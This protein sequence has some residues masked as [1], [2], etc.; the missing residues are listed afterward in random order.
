VALGVL[1]LMSWA[2]AM[3]GQDGDFSQGQGRTVHGRTAMLGVVR[4]V[5]GVV[6]HRIHGELVALNVPLPGQFGRD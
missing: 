5:V 6:P 1:L 3:L 2:E 4:T